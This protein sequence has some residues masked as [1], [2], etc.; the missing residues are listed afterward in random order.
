MEELTDPASSLPI[1][2]SHLSG[3]ADG[4]PLAS[5]PVTS[6]FATSEMVHQPAAAPATTDNLN[7]NAPRANHITP[8]LTS[9]GPTVVPPPVPAAQRVSTSKAS[10]SDS[11]NAK[12][13]LAQPCLLSPENVVESGQEHTGRWTKEEHD[14][15]LVGLQMYGKE[16]KKV[17]ARVKTRTVVQ[18]RTHAQKYFQK[19][20]KVVEVGGD[21]VAMGGSLTSTAQ[22]AS[23]ATCAKSS[24][25]RSSRST[26]STYRT[27]AKPKMKDAPTDSSS[28]PQKEIS[29]PMSHFPRD[30]SNSAGASMLL[31]MSND[32]RLAA[33]GI[34]SASA[35]TAGV[36]STAC[37][38]SDAP[39]SHGFA[40]PSA[41]APAPMGSSLSI[42]P[43]PTHDELMQAGKFSDPSPA[44][45]GKRK[46]AEIAAAQMLA[47]VTAATAA[48]VEAKAA[49]SNF[50]APEMETTLPS[51]SGTAGSVS[52]HIA[53]SQTSTK[54]PRDTPPPGTIP[55]AP[56][57]MLNPL[58]GGLSIV[59]P[60]RL[61]TNNKRKFLN[62]Q[63]SP[64][65]PWD[66]QMEALVSQV[67]NQEPSH[68]LNAVD[69]IFGDKTLAN[70]DVRMNAT[71]A[72][73][74]P[75]PNPLPLPLR[76]PRTILQA[77]ICNGSLNEVSQICTLVSSNTNINVVNERD[78]AGYHPLHS[79]AALGVLEHFGPNSLEICGVLISSGADVMCRD[80]NGNTPVHWA[81]RAGRSKL[82]NLLLTKSC[83]L[84]AQNDMGETALHWAMRAGE[85]GVEAVKVLGE[86][87]ARINVFNRISRR[88]L[89]VACE[90][91][92]FMEADS[93]EA[94]KL[95]RK[96]DHSERRITRWNLMNCSSQCR[97]L[98][99]HHEEC[100]GHLAKSDG[101]WEVPDRIN[102]IIS[103]L[104]TRTTESCDP[105]DDKCVKPCELTISN[106]FER[107]TL[108]LLSR[109][110]SAEYLAF[111]ND[112]SK[113]LERK[114]KQQLIEDSKAADA[115][116]GQNV[117]SKPPAVL[118]FTPMV[119]RKIM[120]EAKPREDG[121]SDTAFSAGSLKA[122]RRAAGAVQHAVDCVLVGRNRNAF[123]VVRPPGHHAGINGLLADAESCGF[124]LFNNVAAGAMHAL[125]D[126]MNRP[127]CER[128]AIVDIDA[129][130]GNGTEEIVRKC[131][132]S[133]RLLFFSVH[134]YDHDKPKK[135]S[136]FQ[137]KFFPGTGS[138]DDV[139]HNVINVP[140][141]PMWR[142][143][144]VVKSM[145]PQ[146][147]VE[148]RQTRQRSKKDAAA[149]KANSVSDFTSMRTGDP[150]QPA[151]PS[152]PCSGDLGS[153]SAA[154]DSG[155]TQSATR[156]AAPL[157]ASSPQCPS[158]YLMGTGRLAY[159]RAIQHRLLPAL[160]AFNPDLIILST[161]F[162]A[163]RG[164]VG[165]A[166]HYINGTQAVG[167][168]LE[169][170]D[171]AWTSRKICEIADIC[172]DGRVVSVLEGGYGR[173][174]PPVPPLPLFGDQPALD[175]KSNTQAL[176]RLFFS[177]CAIQHLKGLI[178]PYKAEAD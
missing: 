13:V 43:T 80:P 129:H 82:L 137:Y 143:K 55:L 44:A 140:I 74:L 117:V 104:K 30:S 153:E 154:S 169:P 150:I 32:Q 105:S 24:R 70:V 15:F 102:N 90:G 163:A 94:K 76:N 2:Q 42:L 3:A 145:A 47:G 164:D 29:H 67:R 113:D 155:S 62:G 14:A 136:N 71:E 4:R 148:P 178:D 170:E 123:C 175:A 125:S 40:Y 81:A 69:S 134:L 9:Q 20:H 158:H 96:V 167:L 176:D 73:A 75:E 108:E 93:V 19:M 97:T 98:V 168:D 126:E 159:R 127:R 50:A 99:L 111:I 166:R 60:D 48:A 162:D 7:G 151:A 39:A 95:I 103:A 121:H 38:S 56:P 110:H 147:P 36:Y 51:I 85:R 172:C 119:Q 120:P 57:A 37:H 83:P 53:N 17:A 92:H 87:G 46:L 72:L 84:D 132:D 173:T 1:E 116:N 131:H 135:G 54:A 27:K 63:A 68:D 34:F 122:A 45:C 142:E 21:T 128:C 118:P 112:L 64:L 144:E 77:A 89:D 106:D 91:F 157:P 114:R 138:E 152:K 171:F 124:C 41:L 139:A 146:A 61:A 35:S 156:A 11:A 141:A 58:G 149:R 22:D 16:W 101:D 79:A 59:N 8:A 18:T 130:H 177:E 28:P 10:S 88:P 109:I 161:G 12:N 65:T 5:P 107:A 86:N 100:L 23:H 49:Q 25:K 26:N 66:G 115:A 52:N 33:S 6:T 78:D 174:P 160:R 165:N 31:N 133:G